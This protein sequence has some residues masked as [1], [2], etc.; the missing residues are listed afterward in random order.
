MQALHLKAKNDSMGPYLHHT[1]WTTATRCCMQSPTN[2]CGKSSW[3]RM[4]QQRWSQ[5]TNWTTATHC[6]MEWPTNSCGKYSWCRMP[7][8]GWSQEPNWTTA[9]VLQLDAVRSDRQ[10]HSASTVGAECFAARLI[11]GAKRR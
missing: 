5:E 1:D 3:C 11:T 9:T 8:Q 6:C 10:T 7:Q 4:F 2:S